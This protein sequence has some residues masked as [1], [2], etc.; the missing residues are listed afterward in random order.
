MKVEN[1]R[2]CPV[3]GELVPET[4]ASCPVCMLHAALKSDGDCI[5]SAVDQ[6]ASECELRFEHYQVLKNEN[7]T[8]IELGH[9][10]MGVTYKAFDVRLRCPVALKII[11]ARWIG[12]DSARHRFVREARAA[13]SVRHPNVAAVF[14]LGESGGNYFYAMEFVDGETLEK[15][16]RSSGTL[17]TDVALEVVAQVAAGL[18]AIQKQHLVHRD[19]KP[20]NI[21]VSWEAGLL[22]SI[23]II[24]LGLAKGVAEDTISTVGS[25]VGTPAYAS[26]EQFAGLGTDIRSDLYSLGITLWEMLS[27]KPPF[28]GSA[29]ELMDQ[30]HHAVPPTEKLRNVPAPII[31]LLQVLLA[32]DPGQRFQG[33]AQ[34]R[35]SLTRVKEGLASESLVTANELR[36]TGDQIIEL[37]KGI[38]RKPTKHAFRWLLA[39]CLGVAGLLLGGF[40]FVGY[41][42][43]F[44]DQRRANTVPA[45]KSIA[46]LPF[47]SL[48]SNRDDSYFA[49]GVQDEILSDVACISQL[50]VIS[51]TSV[52]QYRSGSKRDLRQ[53]ADTLGVA[54]ILEGTVRHAANRVRIAIQLV[55]GRT[56]QAIWSEIYDRD[57]NDVFTIQSDVAQTIAS[58][59]KATLS[60]EEKQSIEA[61]PTENLDAYDL[62]LRAKKLIDYGEV[63][64][65]PTGNYEKPL[66]E[67]INFLEQAVR[68]D[69]KFT[70]AYCAAAFAHDEL[71]NSYDPTPTRRSLGDAAINNALRLQPDLP[72][73]H[74]RYAYHLYRCYRDYERAR[75]HLA[76]ARKGMPNDSAA[77]AIA[78]YMDRRQGNF[79][80]AIQELHEAIELDP[81]NP[82]TEL[83]NTFFMARQ[84]SACERAYN[85]SIKLAPDHPILKVLKAYFV[86]FLKTGD[87]AAFRSAL[88][89][90]PESMGEDRDV[91][92]WRLLCALIDRNWQQVTNLVAKYNGSNNDGNFAYSAVPVP[93]TCSLILVARLH[94]VQAD[95]NSSF[96]EIRE[97][98]NQ[99]MQESERDGNAELLSQLAFVDALLGRKSD[100]IAEAKRAAQMLPVSK[101]AVDGPGVLLN[102]AAV[103]AWTNELDLAFETLESSKI[104]NG[105]Y[106]GQLKSDPYWD[107]LRKDPRFEKMLAELARQ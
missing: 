25:F 96:A 13:A 12:D 26:P 28:Q 3:C 57:L 70:L 88:A 73:V 95:M 58:K 83:P 6:N 100:A 72:Q 31:A 51:R 20:S 49:D 53:I 69:S 44:F 48:S 45:E 74:L 75:V 98:L 82:M 54:N 15:H 63:S 101:D 62:Y 65:L 39:A 7:G 76:I 38:E 107:P 23:K 68:L 81:L 50:R 36:S 9:G 33:P 42:R 84:F 2:A 102:L 55:D 61:K 92:D 52:M 37:S 32:K 16:I 60:P 29:A 17:E 10:A 18:T 34:L 67:A 104:P 78:A 11:N 86:T 99:E 46:V 80:K 71:Y 19:I 85:R 66:L 64:P 4:S 1:R 105:I 30:H 35:E 103:Y 87:N 94:G 97:Q 79:Q 59:L 106:Y 47:E 77:M 27:G 90:L 91:L 22:E 5:G 21:M 43:P 41:R 40:L 24:D 93:A 89:A 56:D 14:H 8:P